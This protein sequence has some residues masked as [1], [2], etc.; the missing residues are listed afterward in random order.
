MVTVKGFVANGVKAVMPPKRSH[1]VLAG[2]APGPVSA[3][4]LVVRRGEDRAV[5]DHAAV[6]VGV[7]VREDVVVC[8]NA[9][10]LHEL[11]PHDRPTSRYAIRMKNPTHR[12]NYGVNAFLMNPASRV[13]SV[14]IHT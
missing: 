10:E 1:T 13:R 9:R 8:E 12:P 5:V 14:S 11:E 4:Q 6:R 2:G 7:A 3:P